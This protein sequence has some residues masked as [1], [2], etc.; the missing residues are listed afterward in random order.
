[1]SERCKTTDVHRSTFRRAPVPTTTAPKRAKKECRGRTRRHSRALSW[2][3]LC[4][5]RVVDV[6]IPIRTATPRTANKVMTTSYRTGGFEVPSLLPSR[7]RLLSAPS[8]VS[9]PPWVLFIPVAPSPTFFQPKAIPFR[10]FPGA[11]TPPPPLLPRCRS[12]GDPRLSG[13]GRSPDRLAA[14]GRHFLA[15][16]SVLLVYCWCIVG[17][18]LA[19]WFILWSFASSSV[20][21]LARGRA[22]FQ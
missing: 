22:R 11:S 20:T 4:P 7:T 18:L 15:L 3:A 9:F 21:V 13:Q 2:R 1:M 8:L 17:V 16:V 19:C 6:E 5:R 10:A 12:P 14:K